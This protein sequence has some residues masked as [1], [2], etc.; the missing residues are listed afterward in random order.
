MFLR[1]SNARVTATTLTEPFGIAAKARLTL[2][3]NI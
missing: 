3:V 2:M 1:K